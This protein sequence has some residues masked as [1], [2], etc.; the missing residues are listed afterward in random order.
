MLPFDEEQQSFNKSSLDEETLLSGQFWGELRVFLAV[1]KTK[2]F[3]RAAE[4][5]NTSQPTVSRQV[6]RLQDIVGS[7]LFISTPR[8]VKLTKKGEAL[9]K[10]LSRLDQTLYSITSDLKGET[11]E[12]EG[13]VRVSITDGLNALFA[14]PA[15]LKFSAQYP[16]I[17]LHLKNPL[18]HLNLLENQTDM[19]IGFMPSVSSDIQFRKL[20][21]LH[22]VPVVAKEYIQTYGL[23]TRSNLERH[24]FL[25][26][27]YYA[28]KTGMWESWQRAMSRGRIAHWCDNSFAYG[29]LVKAGHGVGLLGSFTLMEPCFVPLDID[30]RIAVP[31]FLVALT[32]RLNARPVRLV[33]DWLSEVFS[34]DN[35]WFTDELRLNNPPSE[36]DAGFR[37]MF[38]LEESVR[39]RDFR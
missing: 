4:I 12:A 22:F 36:Y 2:S 39:R 21:Q 19:M 34:P 27:E 6:K 9:A 14:A 15:L 13:T 1:A 24:L 26:T 8:G 32:D 10:A 30:V 7:Q 17:Q 33:F 29:M 16:K 23:P 37:R 11:R 18:N 3:N 35:P 31:L 5:T 38:N 20:G 28:A 25:Q